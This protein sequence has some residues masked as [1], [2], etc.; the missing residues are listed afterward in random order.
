MATKIIKESK[1]EENTISD[2]PDLPDGGSPLYY[3]GVKSNKVIISGCNRKKNCYAVIIDAKSQGLAAAKIVNSK[4]E[5]MK[6]AEKFINYVDNKYVNYEKLF[7]RLEN[8]SGFKVVS[9]M[10]SRKN[11]L[12][13]L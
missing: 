6:L 5:A 4:N 2:C 13:L 9:T 12:R 3:W 10:M 8:E 7:I 1:F 11:I